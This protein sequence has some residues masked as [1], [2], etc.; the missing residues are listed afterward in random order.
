[1]KLVIILHDT[2]IIHEKAMYSV[3]DLLAD[4]GGL[5][6][7]FVVAFAI[8]I[9]R[10][11]SSLFLFNVIKK[12]YLLKEP[13]TASFAEFFYIHNFGC[14]IKSESKHI[15]DLCEETLEKELDSN[16]LLLKLRQFEVLIHDKS[17]L[18]L[19]K[20]S[21]LKN[22]RQRPIEIDFENGTTK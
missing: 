10:Y 5:L 6:D 20:S 2:Q 8:I 16:N 12:L 18:K 13:I 3:F 11:N 14:C 9:Q 1:M 19:V 22:L 17:L 7:I 4:V 15:I 21:K